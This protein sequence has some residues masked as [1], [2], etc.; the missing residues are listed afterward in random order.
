M[1]E[2]RGYIETPKIGRDDFIITG[3]LVLFPMESF[4]L[5]KNQI[6]INTEVK[7]IENKAS[8][9]FYLRVERAI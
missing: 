9:V 2:V 4:S 6:A 5:L 1:C 8:P 7:S 3:G